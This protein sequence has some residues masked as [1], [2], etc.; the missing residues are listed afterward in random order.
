MRIFRRGLTSPNPWG[1]LPLDRP[2]GEPRLE[3]G[4]A[5]TYTNH[6]CRC[7]DCTEANRRK[8][9]R[10]QMEKDSLPVRKRSLDD[11]R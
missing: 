6:G 7:N 1:P 2:K 4:S 11:A 5:S 8:Q 10:Y 9:E 3:H